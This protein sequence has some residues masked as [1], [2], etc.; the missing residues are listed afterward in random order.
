MSVISESPQTDP[1]LAVQEHLWKAKMIMRAKSLILILCAVGLLVL[2]TLRVISA[3]TISEI[4]FGG[5]LAI[6]FAG[7]LIITMFENMSFF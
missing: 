2:T 3:T 5:F 7:Y 1:I 6:M 4:L